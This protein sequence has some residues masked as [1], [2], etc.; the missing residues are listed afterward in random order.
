[1][2]ARSDKDSK[3]SKMAMLNLTHTMLVLT[4][5]LSRSFELGSENFHDLK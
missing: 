1:M 5:L 4:S 2:N 3:W